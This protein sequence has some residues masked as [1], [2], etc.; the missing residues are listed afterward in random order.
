MRA[1]KRGACRNWRLSASLLPNSRERSNRPRARDLAHP[2]ARSDTR[3]PSRKVFS[4]ATAA[5]ERPGGG[6]SRDRVENRS[7]TR[8]RQGERPV[9]ERVER[10]LRADLDGDG[11]LLGV[12]LDR[13]AG[14]APVG[15]GADLAGQRDALL[16]RFLDLQRIVR[17]ERRLGQRL[18]PL[19]ERLLLGILLVPGRSKQPAR[20]RRRHCRGGTSVTDANPL[21]PIDRTQAGLSPPCRPWRAPLPSVPSSRACRRG[22]W[23]ARRGSRARPASRACRSCRRGAPSAPRR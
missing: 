17:G 22:S 20:A 9:V 12:A 14:A 8:A 18:Q 3:S 16:G 11:D 13:A 15:E 5:S 7:A 2:A 19:E 21:P 6:A 4:A 1:T 23:A 10:N